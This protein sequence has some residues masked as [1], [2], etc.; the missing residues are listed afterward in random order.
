MNYSNLISLCTGSY[1]LSSIALEPNKIMLCNIST[2][3]RQFDRILSLTDL[4]SQPSYK[5]CTNVLY[6]SFNMQCCCLLLINM[7]SLVKLISLNSLYQ[8]NTC[9]RYITCFTY[10]QVYSK[11][12]FDFSKQKSYFYSHLCICPVFWIA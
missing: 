4:F 1:F 11:F 9:F 5:V 10:N 12:L 7:G 2:S 8:I 6:Q 3:C